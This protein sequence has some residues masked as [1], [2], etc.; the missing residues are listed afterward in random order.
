MPA[1]FGDEAVIPGLQK[2]GI[3]LGE[4]RNYG[5]V[6]CVEPSVIGAFGRNNGGY[7][8]LARVVDLALNNG[9]DRLS[10]E[11]LG[12]RTGIASDFNC[13]EDLG[14]AVQKQMAHF[15]RLLTIED[16]IIDMVQAALTPHVLAS[17]FIPGCIAKGKD[18]T[19]GGA[20][21]NWIPPFG[22]GLATAADSLAAAKKLVF[23][24]R[25][26]SLD[27]LNRALDQPEGEMAEGIRA[28]LL[29]CP[30]YGNDNEEADRLARFVAEVFF[31][32]VEKYRTWRGGGPFVGGLFSLSSTV[33]H[34]WK[35]GATADGR[36]PRTPV[37]DSIS[38]TNGMDR[39]GPTAVLL[40]ASILD[41]SRCMGGNVLNLKFTPG[42]IESGSSLDKFAQLIKTYLV[43]LR[44]LEVQIN[45]V[46]AETLRDA[47]SHPERYRD[48]VIRV[49]GYSARFVELAREI[50]NDIIARTEHA[51]L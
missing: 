14:A 47:Q 48:L 3:P 34:G 17:A 27:Q 51:G 16:N 43:D 31:N 6:G 24:D 13:F 29:R 41:H 28:A 36:L 50:Q 33:P 22:V 21:Y 25:V 32:E 46:S 15:V 11:S 26:C 4:A 42:A 8:N 1:L 49:A 9:I 19:A 39:Q 2:L 5:M 12:P 45:V 23:E 7:F 44:G 38:P 37:S 30:K 10:G 18:I 40:S 35:T 20:R